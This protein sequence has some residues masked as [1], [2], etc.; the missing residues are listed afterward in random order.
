MFLVLFFKGF[1]WIFFGFLLLVFLVLFFKG[2]FGFFF[3]FLL[4]VFLVLFFKGFFG[5]FFGFLLLV[6]LVF[7]FGVP[8][9]GYS[10]T[11]AVRPLLHKLDNA[12]HENEYLAPE[13]FG[14]VSRA[15]YGGVASIPTN[16]RNIE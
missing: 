12:V 16:G 2:F 15:L 11:Y 5:F 4:L 7:V 14:N 9:C 3:G 13:V 6:F 10:S 1:F 8:F